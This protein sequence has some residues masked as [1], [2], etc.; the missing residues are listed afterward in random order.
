MRIEGYQVN[1]TKSDEVDS[2]KK[3]KA[4]KLKSKQQ[5][6]SS[7]KL[8]DMRKPE[9]SQK[10]KHLAQAKRLADTAPDIRMDKV[11]ALKERISKG[12]YHVSP[13][14]LADKM[15]NEHLVTKEF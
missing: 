10:A 11:N 15:I 9:I 12:E 7:K 5:Q 1:Q 2:A 6:H 4:D 3:N 14:A 13:E 8:S